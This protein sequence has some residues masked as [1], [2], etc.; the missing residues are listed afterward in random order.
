MASRLK[1]M[2]DSNIFDEFIDGPDHIEMI[3]ECVDV[4]VTHVQFNELNDTPDPGKKAM[5]LQAFANVVPEESEDSEGGSIP[6]E[7]AV[8]SFSEWGNAKWGSADD[9]FEQ[10][11]RCVKAKDAL[12]GE[13]AIRHDLVLVTE[14]RSFRKAMF[15]LGG[16]SMS[17][18][19]LLT[20]CKS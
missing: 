15:S 7:S 1:C 16:K 10:L 5:L 17:W 13:T 4:F 19:E 6:T 9:L 20:I 12:I 14:D 18:Q 8:W 3:A 11:Q 2:F